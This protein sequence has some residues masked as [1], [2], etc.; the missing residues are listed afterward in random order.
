MTMQRRTVLHTAGTAALGTLLAGCGFTLR[1]P[2]QFDFATLYSSFAPGSPLGA[3]FRRN[4]A[5]NSSV[6]VI[7]DSKQLNEA[8]V[9]LDVLSDLRQKVVVGVNASGQVR[10]F[11]LRLLFKFKLRRR[12]GTE[13]IPETEITQQRDLSFNEAAALAKEAEEALLYRDMEKDVVQQLL[14]RL[15]TIRVA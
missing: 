9:L 7:T 2:P 1:Q 10:E 8:D 13:L 12:D 11:Q 3:Q 15:S 6:R 5:S 4:L 14:R